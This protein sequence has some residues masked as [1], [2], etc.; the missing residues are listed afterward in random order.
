MGLLVFEPAGGF[1]V[2]RKFLVKARV[3]PLPSVVVWW[4]ISGGLWPVF[5][6]SFAILNLEATKNPYLLRYEWRHA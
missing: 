2:P 3:S 4:Q 1:A 5:A 6:V